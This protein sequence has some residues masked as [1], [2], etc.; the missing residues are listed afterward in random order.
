ME[1]KTILRLS[2]NY[3]HIAK[4][5]KSLTIGQTIAKLELVNI[6]SKLHSSKLILKL[7]LQNIS[8]F[9]HSHTVYKLLT[10]LFLHLDQ[11]VYT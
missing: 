10:N 9:S 1:K 11:N 6:L 7:A 5:S 3:R 2:R 4:F 8:P